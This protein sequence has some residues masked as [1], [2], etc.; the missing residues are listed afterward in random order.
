MDIKE[1]IE[2]LK[3]PHQVTNNVTSES[4]TEVIYNLL[5]SDIFSKVYSILDRSEL[6]DLDYD[7]IEINDLSTHMVYLSDDFDII[8][9][10]DFENDDYNLIIERAE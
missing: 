8:L 7:N 6:L 9:D 3:L 4:D 2:Q 5:N 10:A 1:F